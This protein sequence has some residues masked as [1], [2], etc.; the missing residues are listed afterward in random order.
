MSDSNPNTHLVV[1]SD[2]LPVFTPVWA[3]PQ[4]P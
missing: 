2:S 3:S 1:K 4:Q